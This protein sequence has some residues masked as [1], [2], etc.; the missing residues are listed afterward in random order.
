MLARRQF[1]LGDAPG[2][3]KR[4]EAYL[5]AMEKNTVRY[6]GDYP[7]YLRKQQLERI[8][9]EYARAG[10]WADALASLARFVD[11]P[12]YSGG[13]PPVDDVLVR[14][15]RQ[16]EASPAKERYQTLHDWTMPAKDR[17]VARILTSL[18][19]GDM[20]PEAFSQCGF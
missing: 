14:L 1:Q 12:A 17:R 2:G 15:L 7:L 13:D 20:A 3:R 18:A 10:L 11:A 16:I 5:E 8:A 9:A 6:S 4:L 19:A